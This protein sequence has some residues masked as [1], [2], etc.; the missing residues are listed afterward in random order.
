MDDNISGFFVAAD[1]YGQPDTASFSLLHASGEGF[2]ALYRGERAGKFRVF[3]CLKPEWRDNPLQVT[4]LRKEFETGYTLRHGNICETY[5]YTILDEYGPAIE[6]EWIDGV[7]LEEYL[8]QG[9]PD[10]KT[11]RR[12]AGELCDALSYLHSRQVIHRDI[13]PANI[14]VTHGTGNIKLIDFGLADSSDSAILKMPAGT[15]RYAAPE[16][17]AGEPGSP[18]SDLYSLGK[19]LCQMTHG[20]KR[21]IAKCL[22][23]DPT[24]RFRTAAEL[25]DALTAPR[26]WP[27][28]LTVLAVL[29]FLGALLPRLLPGRKTAPAEAPPVIMTPA[30]AADTVIRRDTLR[31]TPPPAA[32]PAPNKKQG[33]DID[34]IFQEATDLLEDRT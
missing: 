17:L 13:K 28:V 15:R 21:V 10:E 1:D 14:I 31:P 32:Q 4:R 12:M 29:V 34:R 7:T 24:Q 23:K 26:R 16:V 2:C 20:H 8:R 30:P 19:V 6:M 9:L 3:K 25:K 11:F 33:N 18:R 22:Q 5:A 27:L